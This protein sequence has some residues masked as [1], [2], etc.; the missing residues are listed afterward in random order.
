ML[1]GARHFWT[2]RRRSTS[3]KSQIRLAKGEGE[4]FDSAH[5]REM[6]LLLAQ[7]GNSFEKSGFPSLNTS[8]LSKLLIYDCFFD[9]LIIL[10]TF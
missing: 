6:K 8:K 10:F 7:P 2:G 5:P 3:Y 1:N 4:D 9:K